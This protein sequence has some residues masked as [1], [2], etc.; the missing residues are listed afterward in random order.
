[1]NTTVKQASVILTAIAAVH[2]DGV[3]AGNACTELGSST[4]G[5]QM[6]RGHAVIGPIFQ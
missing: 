4:A 5:R 1:M 6:M 3:L 2:P